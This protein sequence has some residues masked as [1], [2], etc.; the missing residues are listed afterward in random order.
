MGLSR[1]QFVILTAAAAAGCG[2]EAD[3]ARSQGSA[4]SPAVPDS[5][6]AAAEAVDAGP[7]G[8]FASDRV[9]DSFREQGFFVIRRDG[10]VFALSSICTHKGCKVRAQPDQ[11]FLCKCHGSKFTPDGKVLNGPADRD[12]PRLAVAVSED[13]HVLVNLSRPVLRRQQS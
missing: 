13:K 1:R 10:Q 8:G 12:L 9:Y 7:V 4:S 3:E 6:P 2:R 11:S 5:Q